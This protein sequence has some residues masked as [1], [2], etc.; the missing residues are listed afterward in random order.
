MGLLVDDEHWAVLVIDTTSADERKRGSI[1][2]GDTMRGLRIAGACLAVVLTMGLLMAASA[3]AKQLVL[4]TES[5][6]VVSSG[7]L[8][9]TSTSGSFA[10]DESEEC[11]TKVLGEFL[12]WKVSIIKE[13]SG[14]AG[15]LTQ[16]ALQCQLAG[17]GIVQ[18]EPDPHPWSIKLTK[19]GTGKVKGTMGKMQLTAVFP[20]GKEC[21]YGS[22]TEKLT[23]PIVEGPLHPI[24]LEPGDPSKVVFKLRKMLSGPGCFAKLVKN[25]FMY[26]VQFVGGPAGEEPVLVVKQ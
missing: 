20:D 13:G 3:S 14:Y 9:A 17:G 21:V 16:E 24:P 8:S 18:I 25:G 22:G 19:G 2:K 5:G 12:K 4:S 1:L 6:G 11:G 23:F 15:G 7:T 26:A 10:F